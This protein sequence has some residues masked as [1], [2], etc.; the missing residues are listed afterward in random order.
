MPDVFFS[1]SSKDEDLARNLM[2]VLNSLGVNTFLASVS[3]LPGK[4]WKEEIFKNLRESKWVFFLATKHSCESRA[5]MHEIG[6][7]LILEKKL[8]PLMWGVSTDE[9]PEWIQDRQA[10][11]LKSPTDEKARELIEQVVEKVKADRIIGYLVLGALGALL[12][13]ALMKD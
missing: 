3:L 6:G 2:D 7:A 11:D 12:I 9:L 13:Y 4:Q 5:V 1:Y 10:I 8:I